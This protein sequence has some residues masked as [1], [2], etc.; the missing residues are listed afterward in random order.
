MEMKNYRF[1]LIELLVVISI[2][3]VLASLLLPALNKAR[4]KAMEAKC[5]SNLSQLYKG[6][7]FYS[8]DFNGWAPPFN[9]NFPSSRFQG[10]F[11]PDSIT[12]ANQWWYWCLGINRY[13]NYPMLT[14][15]VPVDQSGYGMSMFVSCSALG[16]WGSES[17]YQVLHWKLEKLK[18]ASEIVVLGDSISTTSLAYMTGTYT[19]AWPSF[20]HNKNTCMVMGDGHARSWTYSMPR[21]WTAAQENLNLSGDGRDNNPPWVK[22]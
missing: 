9:Y 21:T 4:L 19:T 11:G 6:F 2:I 12:A 17:T 18:Y 3:A 15:P 14:C 16:K 5:T 22:W 8:S 7:L 13:V 1:T 10:R 20:R